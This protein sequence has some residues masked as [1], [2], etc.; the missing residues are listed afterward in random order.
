MHIGNHE[1]PFRP[2]NPGRAVLAVWQKAGAHATI[3]K[4]TG[5]ARVMQHLQDSRVRRPHP[6]QLALVQPFANAARK[7]EALL[8]EELG[9]LHGG[10]G[11]VEG[12]EDQAHRRLY[13]SVWVEN[14]NAVV[15]INQ[16]DRRRYL[17]LAAPSLVQH[18]AS[19]PRFEE[20]KFCFRHGPF[21]PEQEPVIEVRRRRFHPRR[22]SVRPPK[23]TTR[24]SGAS[25][26]NSEPGA[27]P[28]APSPG[29]PC[30]GRP[31]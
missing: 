16:T 18:P 15:P 22:E 8:V 17:K 5:I 20:M 24:S 2:G 14:Q 27:R 29:R 11:A 9:G 30:R 7:P 1:L 25:R 31:H 10:S 26:R 13:F 28:P 21:Q 23:N 3:D 12:L 4:S 6:M 19:H